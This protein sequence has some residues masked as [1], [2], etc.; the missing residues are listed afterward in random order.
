[1]IEQTLTLAAICQV[2]QNVQ[3]LSRT[4][5]VDAEQIDL[6]FNSIINTTP[7]N[8]LDVYGGEMSNLN[9]GLK[10]L[11]DHLGSENSHKDP[12]LTRYIVSLMALER[13]LAKKPNVLNDLAHRIEQT[14]RQLEHFD[15]H[16]ETIAASLASI[17]SDLISPLTAPIQVAGNPEFLKQT[18]VQH[19]IRAL[20]LA[21]IRAAV[22]WRQVGG[23]RRN[24]LFARAKIVASAQQLLSSY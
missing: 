3:T 21:G 1:M 10:A 23:K 11:C 18:H 19:K 5:Q 15:I 2:A 7:A 16:S 8:T 17:Y 13:K 20:L 9:I 12:E 24:I 4:G 6:L 22:L 14:Q